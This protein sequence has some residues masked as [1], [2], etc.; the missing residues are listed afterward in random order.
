MDA[1]IAKSKIY[2]LVD[3]P[4]AGGTYVKK[5]W[6]DG[7]NTKVYYCKGFFKKLTIKQMPGRVWRISF[8]F[9]E[10]WN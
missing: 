4:N 2:L 5:S 9:E 6:Y 10:I 7:S 8:D 1:Y 3:Y